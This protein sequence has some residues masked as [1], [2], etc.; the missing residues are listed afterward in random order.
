[1]ADFS[2]RIQCVSA[3]DPANGCLAAGLIDKK[4]DISKYYFHGVSH[5]IG[6]DTHD[7]YL[8]V[9]SREY[10][11]IPLEPGMVIS[12]E[13]G[14]YMAERSLGIRVEDDLLITRDGCEVLS[15]SIVKEISDIEERL[16]AKIKNN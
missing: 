9:E 6:L 1:M 5:L 3:K 2:Y 14:L 11:N 10:K 4:E 12:D 13:P 8:S 15:A 7:P 16:A